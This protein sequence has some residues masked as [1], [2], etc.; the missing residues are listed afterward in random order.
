ML[1]T[2]PLLASAIAAKS[3]SAC[4]GAPAACAP[5]AAGAVAP[6]AA[7]A[8]AGVS[9]A[10][11][12]PEPNRA[13]IKEIVRIAG[14]MSASDGAGLRLRWARSAPVQRSGALNVPPGSVSGIFGRHDH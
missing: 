9:V 11:E 1:T 8:F 6:C 4:I 12:Q 2:A 10:G 13:A 3:G 5:V 7:G 14:F